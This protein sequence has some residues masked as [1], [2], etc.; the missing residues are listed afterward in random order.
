VASKSAWRR[1]IGYATTAAIILAGAASCIKIYRADNWCPYPTNLGDLFTLSF[2]LDSKVR[3]RMV[4]SPS[5]PE[6]PDGFSDV[7][8]FNPT[9][10]VRHRLEQKDK[11]YKIEPF[12]SEI[13]WRVTKSYSAREK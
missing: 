9:E 7:F 13:L 1:G 6:I 10:E 8:L 12:R 2:L 4:E 3:V 11:E 5:V